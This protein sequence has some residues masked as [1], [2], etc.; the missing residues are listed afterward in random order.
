MNPVQ[1]L[2]QNSRVISM[3][4]RVPA[5]QRGT[6]RPLLVCWCPYAPSLQ[7]AGDATRGRGEATCWTTTTQA[8]EEVKKV[9]RPG[10]FKNLQL[11]DFVLR[12]H[13]L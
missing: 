6:D 9:S 7:A 5:S 11:L 13:L 1:L 2:S 3:V 8:T 10:C 4:T 12:F